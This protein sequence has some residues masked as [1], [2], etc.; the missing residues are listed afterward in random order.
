MLT[1]RAVFFL[2]L[3]A[4]LAYMH[5]RRRRVQ[6]K[7]ANHRRRTA[8]F[9]EM[10]RAGARPYY[11]G[12]ARPIPVSLP[13]SETATTTTASVDEKGEMMGLRYPIKAYVV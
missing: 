13:L 7:R 6:Q 3:G 1:L 12:S 2:L 11:A 10:H 8:Q 9:Q 5:V 4:T